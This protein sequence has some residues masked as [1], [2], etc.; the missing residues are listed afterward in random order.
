MFLDGGLSGFANGS[1]ARQVRKRAIRDE[2]KILNMRSWWG[3]IAITMMDRLGEDLV[4]GIHYF[5]HDT[6]GDFLDAPA[7]MPR[8]LWL[9]KS[10][11]RGE[12]SLRSYFEESSVMVFQA[13]RLDEITPG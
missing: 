10:G 6:L 9:Y 13:M 7:E 4:L 1:D 5:E 8:V 3:R 11:F 12:V 2:S